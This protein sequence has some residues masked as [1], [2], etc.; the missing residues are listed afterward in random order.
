MEEFML[1]LFLRT[2]ATVYLFAAFAL[3]RAHPRPA[4]PR[5]RP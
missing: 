5:G 4:A 1:P 2:V 3:I